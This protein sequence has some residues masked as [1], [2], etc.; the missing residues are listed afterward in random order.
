M[1]RRAAF[2]FVIATLAIA[3]VLVFFYRAALRAPAAPNAQTAPPAAGLVPPSATGPAAPPPEKMRV[4]LY[5][6]SRDDGL[7]RPEERDIVRPADMDTLGDRLLTEEIA[8]P[9]TPG[10]LPALPAGTTLHNFIAPGNGLAVADLNFDPKWKASPGSSEELM[11]VGA[12]VDC[13]L[14]NLPQTDHVQILVNGQDVET[15]AGHVDLTRPL[16]MMRDVIGPE[17]VS[18]PGPSGSTAATGAPR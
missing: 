9:S 14:Q 18:P 11:A 7:L 12:V 17:A 4:T 6:V 16:P 3:V 2:G 5:F 15:L 1:S 10:L 13:L 8:G